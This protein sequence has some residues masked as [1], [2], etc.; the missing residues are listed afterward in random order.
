MKLPFPCPHSEAKN[1]AA[2]TIGT[3]PIGPTLLSFSVHSLVFWLL[4][5]LS[6]GFLWHQ[7]PNVYIQ[8]AR[9]SPQ[10]DH[11]SWWINTAPSLPAGQGTQGAHS[12]VCPKAPSRTELQLSTAVIFSEHTI[13]WLP[14]LPC[15]TNP[16]SFWSLQESS[17]RSMTDHMVSLGG[18]KKWLEHFESKTK[19]QRHGKFPLQP[20][21]C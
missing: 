6:L 12:T 14:S 9:G 20:Q 15:L 10:L 8:Q 11:A 19:Q 16:F 21:W 4:P 17:A 3:L 18:N 5:S 1:T 13:L 7:T 2:G